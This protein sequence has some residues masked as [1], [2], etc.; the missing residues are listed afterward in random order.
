MRRRVTDWLTAWLAD[1][2]HPF[3]AHRQPLTHSLTHSLLPLRCPPQEAVRI[4]PIRRGSPSTSP[5]TP[6][7]TP[8]HSPGQPGTNSAVGLAPG[9]GGGSDNKGSA[10]ALLLSDEG[11]FVRDILLDELAK[12]RQG[13]GGMGCVL[14]G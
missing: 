3:D 8:S 12:V 2:R 11:E 10:L 6:G 7:T 4:Q 14:W 5:S 13:D 9:G 1:W